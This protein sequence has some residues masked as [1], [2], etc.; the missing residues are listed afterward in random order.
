MLLQTNS[1]A[2]REISDKMTPYLRQVC[3]IPSDFALG[4]S[5]N[6]PRVTGSFNH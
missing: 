1:I 2:F 5:A 3:G 6:M 4:D